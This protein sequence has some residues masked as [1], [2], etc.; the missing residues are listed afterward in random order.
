ML[1]KGRNHL[2][3]LDA[4]FEPL[5]HVSNDEIKF[6]FR[7]FLGPDPLLEP[8]T[9]RDRDDEG[10]RTWTGDV[11]N[12]PSTVGG[13]GFHA[14]GKLPRFLEVDFHALSEFG[15][16]E[17]ADLVDWPFGY[18]ELE[19]Y[20]AE[21]ERVVGVAG[22]HTEQPV[23]RVA[24]RPVSD[25]AGRRHVLRRRH[26]RGR[27]E[28][29]LPPLPRADRRQQR[30]VRRPARVQQLRVLRPVRLPDRRQG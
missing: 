3:A 24:V 21:A 9:F 7:H 26:H 25:A 18:D 22:D 20:Y 17:G 28:A 2:L 13:G 27:D 5:G 16:I 23:R 1:E 29:R 30:R 8:R 12:L 14:D 4:P 15:P 11:N 10:D 6:M 19:P